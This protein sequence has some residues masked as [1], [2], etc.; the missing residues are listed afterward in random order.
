M[1]KCDLLNIQYGCQACFTL[2][3]HKLIPLLFHNSILQTA[4]TICFNKKKRFVQFFQKN[5]ALKLGGQSGPVESKSR[6]PRGQIRWPQANGP[7]L[8]TSLGA[9][10]LSSV[11]TMIP[12]CPH[13]PLPRCQ[14]RC[15]VVKKM[16]SCQK[17][18]KC[19][20]V[21][22][23]DYGGGSQKKLIDI[24]RFTHIDVN[25]D[26][27][28]DGDQKPSKCAKKVFLNNFGDLHI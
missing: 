6:L 15:Q 14:K 26:I 16:S 13:F 4:S 17:D 7:V 18:V 10:S 22:H 24:M 12:I 28:Y 8:T 11:L 23:M 1:R 27:T 3:L 9:P 21:K 25:F 2:T 19:Q 5:H 20:K